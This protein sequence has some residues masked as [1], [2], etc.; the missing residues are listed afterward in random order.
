MDCIIEYHGVILSNDNAKGIYMKRREAREAVFGLLFETE[1]HPSDSAED[2]FDVSCDNRGIEEDS[3]VRQA[4]FGVME[5]MEQLDAVIEQHSNGWKT[6]RMS[7]MSRAALRLCIWEM[8][9]GD[10]IPAAVSINE[11]VELVKKYDDEKARSFVNGILNAVKLTL[12]K[13]KQSGD[14]GNGDE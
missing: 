5:N 13:Q 7:G 12:E 11:A 4:Y 8:M 2:I 10:G 6:Y 9:Y 1:F 3:Y 14:A